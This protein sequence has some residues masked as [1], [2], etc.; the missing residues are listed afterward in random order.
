MS[1]MKNLWI[2]S[3]YIKIM[4]KLLLL[5]SIVLPIFTNCKNSEIES[6]ENFDLQYAYI[7]NNEA[8]SKE[9]QN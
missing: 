6:N 2:K 1:D 4:K 3:E 7:L 5:L 8:I 9:E